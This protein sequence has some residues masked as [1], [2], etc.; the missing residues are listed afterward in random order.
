MQLSSDSNQLLTFRHVI[1][2]RELSSYELGR[3]NEEGREIFDL[4]PIGGGIGHYSVAADV[5]VVELLVVAD[6]APSWKRSV[7]TW[8]LRRR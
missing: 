6:N 8:Q 7:H 5:L 2:A 4:K 1:L 3:V